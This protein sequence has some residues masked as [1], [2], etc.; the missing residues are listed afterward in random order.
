MSVIVTGLVSNTPDVYTNRAGDV[1]VTLEI[2]IKTNG[3]DD[4]VS[5][6]IDDDALVALVLREVGVGAK[7]MIT[8]RRLAVV[9]RASVSRAVVIARDVKVVQS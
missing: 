1:S 8:G 5:V 6:V 7:V 3:H 9:T 4:S 2:S